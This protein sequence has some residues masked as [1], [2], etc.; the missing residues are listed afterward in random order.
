MKRII[1][2]NYILTY[3]KQSI[4][5]RN[6]SRWIAFYFQ[7]HL[8]PTWLRT[9]CFSKCKNHKHNVIHGLDRYWEVFSGSRKYMSV[10]GF[11]VV[12]TQV[13]ECQH[14]R[15]PFWEGPPNRPLI[16]TSTA[17]HL[18][19]KQN[20]EGEQWPWLFILKTRSVILEVTPLRVSMCFSLK[21]S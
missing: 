17:F 12:W 3:P 20:R 10:I 16:W 21:R 11:W 9:I 15:S 1:S 18:S 14:H 8:F 6:L 19:R 13:R 7:L 2:Y 5:Q 4:Y